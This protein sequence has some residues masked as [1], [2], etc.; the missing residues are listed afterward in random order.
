MDD[1]Q[2]QQEQAE[3]VKRGLVHDV[4]VGVT[5]GAATGAGIAAAQAA[6]GQLLDRP[7]KEQ[8]PQVVLPPGV[9]KD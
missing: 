3:V 5:T 4:V 1:R 7:P 2:E 6:V 9:E 8:P